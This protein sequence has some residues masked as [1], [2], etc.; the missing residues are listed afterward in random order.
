MI[1]RFAIALLAVFLILFGIFAVTNL[2][3]AFGH[4]I[5][6]FIAIVAGICWLAHVW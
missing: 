2:T 3:V 4:I 1:E 6:G 5:L